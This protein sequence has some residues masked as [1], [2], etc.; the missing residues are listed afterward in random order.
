MERSCGTA[1]PVE[2]VQRILT[3]IPSEL[4]EFRIDYLS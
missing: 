4:N 1:L 3:P 2:I